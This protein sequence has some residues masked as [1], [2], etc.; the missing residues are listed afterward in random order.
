MG[1]RSKSRTG[2]KTVADPVVLRSLTERLMALR[3]ESRRRWGTLTAHEMLC[4]LGD[5]GEMVL[6]IRRRERP[7]PRRRRP[8][9]KWLALWTPMRWSHG[10][11]TN[12]KHDPR[13]A[14]TRP[15]DFASDLVRALSAIQGIATAQADALEPVHGLFGTMSIRDWQRWAYKHTDHHLRQFG[16]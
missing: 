6:M 11:Q 7:I 1:L 3:P 16:L 10:Q 13:I 9:F 15:S 2:V 4:H 8:I 5:A 12:P 14:G